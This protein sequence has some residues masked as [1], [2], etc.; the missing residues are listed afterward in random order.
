MAQNSF[1]PAQMK[2]LLQYA[3]KQLGKS[4]DELKNAFAQGGLAGITDSLSPAEAGKAQAL[5]GDKEKTAQ[6]LNSPA[7]QQLLQQLLGAE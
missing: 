4:P 3:S 1:S 6:L 5:L 7:V 2:K